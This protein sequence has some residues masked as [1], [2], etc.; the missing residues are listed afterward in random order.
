MDFFILFSSVAGVYGQAG[1]ANYAAANTFQGSF[2][3]YRHSLGLAC[4]VIDVGV[5]QGVGY[6]SRNADILNRLRAMGY[7]QLQEED[8]L[9]AIELS[10]GRSLALS[11]AAA[12]PTT[13][14]NRYSNPGHIISRIPATVFLGNATSA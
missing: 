8:L 13:T 6:I 3:Q 2:A 9:E 1:Q 4:S 12:S 11:H 10:I 5:M 14:Q 7:Y